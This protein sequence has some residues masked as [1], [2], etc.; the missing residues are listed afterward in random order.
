MERRRREVR[1]LTAASLWLPSCSPPTIPALSRLSGEREDTAESLGFLLEPLSS[2]TIISHV[3][4]W[5]IG[6]RSPGLA[7]H[8]LPAL[9]PLPLVFLKKLICK[10]SYS[11]M[12]WKSWLMEPELPAVCKMW[13][14]ASKWPLVL[15]RSLGPGVWEE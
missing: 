3:S 13:C 8:C 1:E 7:P 5:T 14:P 6:P 9:S 4:G 15:R 2:D 11:W 12:L 10:Q